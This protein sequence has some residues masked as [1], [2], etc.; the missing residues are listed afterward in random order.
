MRTGCRIALLVLVVCSLVPSAAPAAWSQDAPVVWTSVVANTDRAATPAAPPSSSGDETGSEIVPDPLE[1]MNRAFFHFNDKLYFWIFK[2][3][4]TGYSIVVPEQG[5]VG[6]NNFFSNL[7][8]PI[9]LANCL[10]QGN[11]KGAGNETI[12]LLLNSTLGLAGF[13]D[14][15]KKELNIEKQD[16]DFGQT[17]GTWGMGPVF[18]V[19]VPFL[20]P[21]NLR[22]GLGY[23][24][25]LALDPRSYLSI[26]FY[27]KVGLWTYE[28]VNDH[29]L[30]GGEYEDLKKAAVDPYI[31]KRDAFH[32][33]RQYKINQKRK[34]PESAQ[35]RSTE[36]EKPR[37][38][39][40]FQLW[41][42]EDEGRFSSY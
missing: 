28:E 19:E 16:E 1:P 23:L 27:A 2:P 36:P 22:D 25:D 37:L 17:F 31:A 10:L 29:S 3:L 26:P 4:S 40:N 12:R 6:V 30:S 5:R 9:R 39:G 13:L 32:Q 41:I 33:Y 14:P 38:A 34:T 15:A 35:K 8:T 7:T 18:Y 20:G 11:F 42:P 21:S 24:A